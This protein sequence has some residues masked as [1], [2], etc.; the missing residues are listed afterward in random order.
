MRIYAHTILK[1]NVLSHLEPFYFETR[2][3]SYITNADSRSTNEDLY[4]VEQNKIY[5]IRRVKNEKQKTLFGA[6]PITIDH[7]EFIKED[8]CYQV[9]VKY[10]TEFLRHKVFKSSPSSLVEWVF[11]YE[12]DQMRENYFY[13]PSIEDINSPAIK[14]D[15]MWCL[16]GGNSM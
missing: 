12:N 14:A 1:K 13:V 8:E 15:L 10:K 7:T 3:L 4:Q 9:P 5:Y 11:V 16:L 2:Q 6:F